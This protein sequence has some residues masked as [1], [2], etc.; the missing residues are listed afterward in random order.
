ML[1]PTLLNWSDE[2][3]SSDP[4]Q[5]ATSTAI[6][7]ATI[8]TPTR[9]LP[10]TGPPHLDY[11]LD[12]PRHPW[13][14]R[15]RGGGREGRGVA[16][17]AMSDSP[18]QYALDGDVAV[19]RLDDGKANA[20][21]H[22]VLDDLDACLTK[23]C[24]EAS[25]LA[26]LGRPGRFSAGFDLSVMT[27]GPIEARDLL[28]KGAELFLRVFEAPIPVLLGVSGHALAGGAI[29]LMSA[30]WRVGAAGDFKI[31]LNEVAIGMPVPKF[32]VEIARDR[33]SKRHFVAA[34]NHARIFDAAG[35]LDAGYLDE[36][37]E[38]DAV[39]ARTLEH[40][41]HLAATL[42]AGAFRAT[43]ANCRAAGATAMRA[44]L[45]ADMALFDVAT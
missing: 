39:E 4:A 12:A 11:G 8:A 45:D 29:L 7:K 42:N 35:A 31:G 22:A 19:V 9:L 25:A 17:A 44:G 40:A 2:L 6:V 38:P 18:V 1:P 28:T 37:V 36:V 30:D 24:A 13:G 33:L 10:M 27:A 15:S 23:A 5:E 41:A 21:T 26:I 34:V 32:A 3:S 16:S 20:L 14:S 43:R